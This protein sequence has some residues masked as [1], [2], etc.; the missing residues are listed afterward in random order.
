MMR[1]GRMMGEQGMNIQELPRH[2]QNKERRSVLQMLWNFLSIL[3]ICVMMVQWPVPCIHDSVV[4]P[5]EEE[6]PSRLEIQEW[7]GANMDGELGEKTD[8]LYGAKWELYYGIGT[9]ITREII[10]AERIGK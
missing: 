4:R 6:W 9:K 8:R 3:I 1:I 7:C 10:N 2:P 5:F